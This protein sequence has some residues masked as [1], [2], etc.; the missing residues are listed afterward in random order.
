ML[1]HNADAGGLRIMRI[2]EINYLAADKNAAL[3]WWMGPNNAFYKSRFSSAVFAEQCMDFAA[4]DIKI[5]A[6]K[7]AH[8]G[9]ILDQIADFEKRDRAA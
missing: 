6:I 4:P 9:K 1:M 5:D 3:T 2:V 8:A 7:R